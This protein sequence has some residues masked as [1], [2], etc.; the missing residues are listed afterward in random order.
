M[1]SF[2]ASTA[3]IIALATPLTANETPIET[4]DV[5]F[6]LQDVESSAAAEF[7]ADLEGDLE[8]AIAALVVDQIKDEGSEINID[9]DEFDM[10]NSFQ[11]ALGVESVLTA[12]VEIRNEQ[13]PSKNSFFDLRVTVDE[14]AKLTRDEDGATLIT[15]EREDVYRAMV[16]TFAEGIVKRLR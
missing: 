7:W 15:H 1:K 10:S 16:D 3:A 14:A 2:L 6:E 8:A 13:D 12:K 9:I 11:G 5:T 4:I